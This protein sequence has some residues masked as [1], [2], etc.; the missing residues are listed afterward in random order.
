MLTPTN[1]ASISAFGS[2]FDIAFDPSGKFA[3]APD[4][5][6]QYVAQFAIDPTTGLLADNTPAGVI[7]GQ[8]PTGLA[9]DPSGRFAYAVNRQDNTITAFTIDA[10]TGSLASLGTVATGT[11]PFRLAV[12][13][14][15][16]FVYVT[17][18]SGSISIYAINPD[19]T[20]PSGSLSSLPGTPV[21]V[22]LTAPAGAT[23]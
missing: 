11:Q 23:H 20:L 6:G 10:N 2:P 12:D 3:Y 5:F 22:V 15:G 16:K 9:V 4:G 7:S 19:G 14:T 17:N 18:E 13:P 8:N 1:P 21:S